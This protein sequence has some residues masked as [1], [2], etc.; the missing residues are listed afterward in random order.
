MSIFFMLFVVAAFRDTVKRFFIGST[1]DGLPS[2]AAQSK[3]TVWSK[4]S[5]S[6]PRKGSFPDRRLMP[7]PAHSTSADEFDFHRGQKP[8][9]A[10]ADSSKSR[11][12]FQETL[13]AVNASKISVIPSDS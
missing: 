8:S 12:C 5:S 4:N 3:I 11:V 7:L 10:T 13:V 6:L 2:A 1:P 9:A